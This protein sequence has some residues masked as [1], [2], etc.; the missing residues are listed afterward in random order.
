MHVA[1]VGG[2]HAGAV[3]R[4]AVGHLLSYHG[5]V[6]GVVGVVGSLGGGHAGAV[7]RA[8]AADALRALA[9]V[10]RHAAAADVRAVAVGGHILA[11]AVHRAHVLG[12]EHAESGPVALAGAGRSLAQV[13]GVARVLHVDAGAARKTVV[14]RAGA[15]G[16]QVG[17]R[18]AL[19][20]GVGAVLRH[21]GVQLAVGVVGVDV[22]VLAGAVR[23]L[24]ALAQAGVADRAGVARARAGQVAQ[25][26]LVVAHE[27][28]ALVVR[29]VRVQAV[30]VVRS[31]VVAGAVGGDA[32]AR[33]HGLAG[34]V[35][36]A[37]ALARGNL[38]ADVAVVGVAALG[39]GVV[40]AVDGRQQVVAGDVGLADAA[41]L[42]RAAV[43]VGRLA[44][45]GRA[46]AAGA[47]GVVGDVRADAVVGAVAAVHVVLGQV[48]AVARGG[49]PAPVVEG[50][51]LGR[52]HAGVVRAVA[53]VARGARNVHAGV[54]LAAG[55][56]RGGCGQVHAVPV[57][58][59]A[60]V[61]VRG[62]SQVQ[63]R[64]AERAGGGLGGGRQRREG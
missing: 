10:G 36:R 63:G 16:E 39:V 45:V 43:G 13:R 52:V 6:G 33:G 38:L 7:Q 18:N 56:L 17:G 9:A 47:L 37:E 24:A 31:D 42:L 28:P 22:G 21:G 19:A 14:A 26:A 64:A 4:N 23:G 60:V 51:V 61:A 27:V 54:V 44:L 58:V 50:R 48:V 5:A 15:A 34:E 12:A 30:L 8:V 55:V 29:G 3:Q 32:V 41:E 40:D 25:A 1:E 35:H 62:V 53:E 2:G 46:V 59:D 57:V 11:D 49:R 20:G